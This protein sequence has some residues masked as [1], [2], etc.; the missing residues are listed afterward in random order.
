MAIMRDGVL[1]Q[2]DKP[3]RVYAEPAN[4]FVAGF[5]GSPPMNFFEAYIKGGRVDAGSFSLPLKVGHPAIAQE[6]KK[7][8]LGIRPEEVFDKSLPTNIQA[9]PENTMTA[10]VDVME[11]L[12]HEYVV[13]LKVGEAKIVASLDKETKLLPGDSADFIVNLDRIHVFDGETEVAMR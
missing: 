5:I 2:C 1:Q 8:F 7:V 10:T 9:T 12:G 4:K 13:Y 11:P 3:E 6:G